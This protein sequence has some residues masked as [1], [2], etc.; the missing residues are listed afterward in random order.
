MHYLFAVLLECPY[1][2]YGLWVTLMGS[3]GA[4][5]NCGAS[6]KS[7]ESLTFWSSCRIYCLITTTVLYCCYYGAM[8]LFCMVLSPLHW[9]VWLAYWFASVVSFFAGLFLATLAWLFSAV[10]IYLSWFAASPIF[11]LP[12]RRCQGNLNYP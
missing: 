3:L 1:A 9:C 8:L 11:C 6:S 10:A 12:W 2:I 4:C 5:S 7:L